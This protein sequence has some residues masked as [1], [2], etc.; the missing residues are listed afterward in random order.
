MSE[1]NKSVKNFVQGVFNAEDNS[2]AKLQEEQK[3][4]YSK[5]AIKM[6]HTGVLSPKEMF[7]P[8]IGEFATKLLKGV[9]VYRTLYFVNVLKIDMVY[10]TVI[11]SLISIY[12]MLNNPLM[13]A[14]YDKTRTRW[15]KARPYIIFGSIPYFASTFLLYSG[16]LFLGN[17]AGDDPKKIIFVFTMLF[18]QETF[19]TIYN[20]PRGNLLSLQTA[21]PQDR[22]NVGLLQTYIG[23]VASQGVYTLFGPLMELNNKGYINLPMSYVF[24]GLATLSCSIGAIGNIAMA[25]GCQERIALQP[26]PAPITKTMFYVLKN[27]YALR[28]FIANFAVSWWSNGGYSWDVVTQQEI[29]GGSIPSAIAYLP[30]NALDMPSAA[31]IP[32]FRKIFKDNNKNALITLRLW[33]IVVGLAMVVFG[34]PLIKITPNGKKPWPVIGIYAL[35]YGLNGLNNGP[36]NVFESEVGREINDYTEYVTGE[37]P[38]GTVNIL[39]DLISKVT[40]PINAAFTIFLFKWSGYDPTIPMTPWSQGNVDVYK[41]VFFLFVGIHNFPSIIRVIPYFFYD[42]V[43][44]KR[45]KMYVALNERRALLAKEQTVNENILEMMEN[46]EENVEVK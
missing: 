39:T 44:E 17:T 42:L 29:F 8:A 41:K 6:F 2:A 11:L 19:S 23:E 45:E 4:K 7:L 1:N 3:I 30:Y 46:L 38:D 28:N 21:N 27:K 36:A 35:F 43:G 26:K 31:L 12:D 22:I 14:I 40:S 15:G 24:A 16:A 18:I 20:I 9:D 32:K 34:I 37:R 25:I 10:V 5:L 33:D 13:G